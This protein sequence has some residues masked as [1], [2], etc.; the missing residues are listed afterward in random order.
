MPFVNRL[1]QVWDRECNSNFCIL[2]DILQSNKLQVMIL[3]IKS[4]DG[5]FKMYTFQRTI[6][7]FIDPYGGQGGKQKVHCFCPPI[8]LVTALISQ[9]CL[10]LHFLG[11]AVT[12]NKSESFFSKTKQILY[13]LAGLCS[14]QVLKFSFRKKI[15]EKYFFENI[16]LTNTDSCCCLRLLCIL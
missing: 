12:I 15:K 9:T 10:N 2:F 5:W 13:E 6:H 8:S 11:F 16:I 3:L 7:S 4:C 14:K 1:V